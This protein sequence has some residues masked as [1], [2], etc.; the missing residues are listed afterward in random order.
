MPYEILATS[1]T[2][3]TIIYV[4]DVSTSMTH[5]LG[6]RRRID[7][8]ADALYAAIQQM[9][10]RST[11]GVRIAPRYRL[12]IYAYSDHVYDLL[13]GVKTVDYVA[14]LGIPELATM[15]STDTAR[16]FQQVEKL[17]LRE[18]PNMSQCPAPLVCHMTDGEYTGNDPEDIIR[19]I[20]QMSTPDGQVLVE[21]IFISDTILPEKITDPRR[22]PGITCDSQLINEYAI[23]LRDMSSPLPEGYCMMMREAGYR[24]DSNAVM[25][26][27][28]MTREL[29]E[30]GF[31]MSTA[32]PVARSY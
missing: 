27:P 21:N 3:A 22:W 32:T 23:K 7:V 1:R 6:D 31:V 8:V 30:M 5:P 17:L 12:A 29:V 19:R 11:K 13:D 15:R 14:N 24:I 10:F 9:V 4:L 18:L 26:L 2:P 20:T 28:G 25:M 16:A